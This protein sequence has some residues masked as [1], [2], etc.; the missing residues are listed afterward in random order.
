M[1]QL[2]VDLHEHGYIKIYDLHLLQLWLQE[3]YQMDYIFPTFP[4]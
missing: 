3:L 4:S 1:E 2:F